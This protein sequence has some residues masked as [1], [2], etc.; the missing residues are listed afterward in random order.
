M[1]NNIGYMKLQT[2][3]VIL[4]DYKKLCI[5]PIVIRLRVL[6]SEW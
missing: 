3:N 6:M 2:F 4:D 5:G 1:R